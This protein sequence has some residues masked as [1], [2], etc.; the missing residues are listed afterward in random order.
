MRIIVYAPGYSEF[1]GGVIALHKL[2]HNLNQLGE[3]AYLY[4]YD[5]SNRINPRYDCRVLPSGTV[6]PGNDSV[7][8]YPEVVTGNPAGAT[9]V[10]RWIL[11]TP[12][13]IGGDGVFA[14]T[15]LIFRYSDYFKIDPK[16]RVS[17]TLSA[18]EMNFELFQDRRGERGGSCYL[19]RKGHKKFV[20]DIV[21]HV[22]QIASPD[23]TCID[24]YPILGGNQYLANIFNAKEILFSFDAATFV[25]I[26]A[27]MCGCP[28]VVIPDPGVSGDQWRQSVP[29]SC[30]IAYGLE[31]LDQARRTLSLLPDALREFEQQSIEQTRRFV[32]IL[33]EA[34]ERGLSQV[35]PP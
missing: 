28:A 29:V 7:V 16:Y 5:G 2:C 21:A 14:P 20:P 1:F 3:E 30:G 15:D 33:R 9:H 18:M 31:E 4:L 11:N 6:L 27:A 12:G 17:G 13:V 24:H 8:V 35:A 23:S 34:V 26:Q 19:I 32:E 10:V 22:P 25:C